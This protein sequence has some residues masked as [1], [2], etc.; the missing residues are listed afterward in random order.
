MEL[1]EFFKPDL[2]KFF[3]FLLIICI[4]LILFSYQLAL[5]ASSTLARN[6]VVIYTYSSLYQECISESEKGIL[7]VETY[8][9]KANKTLSE[10]NKGIERNREAYE[11]FITITI[12]PFLAIIAP[13]I[14]R[15][16]LLFLDVKTIFI[17]IYWYFLSCIIIFIYNKFIGR[18]L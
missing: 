2:K 1:K 18:K 9:D 4:F 10:M 16:D 14:I 7:D 15:P 6:S 3:I 5:F 8:K 13:E 11:G 12:S 17:L